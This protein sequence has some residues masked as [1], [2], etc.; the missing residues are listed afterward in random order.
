L[1]NNVTIFQVC[2]SPFWWIDA[3]FVT[4]LNAYSKTKKSLGYQV[5]VDFQINF[6]EVFQENNGF[7]I[8]IGNP[9][10]ISAR[11]HAK[12]AKEDRKAYKKLFPLLEGA[13]DVFSIFL[14]IGNKYTKDNG[15]YSWIVPNKLLV[16]DYARPT[17]THLRRNSLFTAIDVSSYG[18]FETANV[19]PIIILGDKGKSAEYIRYEIERLEDLAAR[20]FTEKDTSLFDRYKT[21]KDFNIRISSGTTGFQAKEIAKYVSETSSVGSIPFVVSGSVD[22]YAVT[23]NKVRYMKKS[24]SRAFITK[25]SSIADTKWDFWR[26]DKIIIAGMTKVIEAYYADHPLAIGVG[27]YGIHGYGGFDPYYLLGILNSKFLT[28]YLNYRFI[29]KHLAGGY[30]AI[31]KSTIERLPLVDASPEIQE[32]VATLAKKISISK[33]SNADADAAHYQNQIDELVYKIYD[34]SKTE[35]NAIESGQPVS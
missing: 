22:P 24:Y 11:E 1:A 2:Q 33:R 16:A 25:N 27:I 18:V 31:N 32:R 7:D 23:Y 14:L 21:F 5:T 35:I 30:L 12:A 3:C 9:P 8:I 29:D 13:F 6:S 15:T 20:R 26:K 4:Q 19:Y 34:L 17:L 10:Y 28:Y